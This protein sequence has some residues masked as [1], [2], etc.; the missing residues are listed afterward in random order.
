ML[1]TL[2]LNKAETEKLIR[3]ALPNLFPGSILDVQEIVRKS[4]N[5][6]TTITAEVTEPP[7]GVSDDAVMALTGE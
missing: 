1:V 3:A 4:Y 2:V 7:Q 6:T 5:D